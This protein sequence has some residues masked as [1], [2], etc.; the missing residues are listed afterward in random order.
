M[1]KLER[2]KIYRKALAFLR[3]TKDCGYNYGCEPMFWQMYHSGLCELINH[4]KEDSTNSPL[5]RMK[6]FFLFEPEQHNSSFWWEKKD[7]A[8]REVCLL[9][10]IEMT[11]T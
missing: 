11:K 4:T 8:S 6:E 2:R 3:G 7:R 5:R 10:C 9:L 1:N